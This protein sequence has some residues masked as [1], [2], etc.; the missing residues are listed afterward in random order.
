MNPARRIRAL[1]LLAGVMLIDGYDLNAM[2]LAIAWLAPEMGL[3]PTSFALV[4]SADLL[5]LGL[6]ALLFAPLGDR[7]GRKPLIVGGCLVIA[8]ATLSTGLSGTVPAF[9]FWRLVTGIGLGTCLANV[10]A[11]SAEVA[12]Q[13]RRST[14]MA[15]VS[16][17]I[18]IGAMLAGF[19]APEVVA[20]GG[21]KMLF[22]IP[23]GIAL[24]LAILLAAVLE[25]GKPAHADKADAAKVPLVELLRPPLLLPM[26]VFTITY[27]IN[28]VALYMLVR[29]TPVLLPKAGFTIE[30]AARIQGLLQGG[31]LAVGIGLA[32]LLDRWK[33]GTTFVLGYAVVALSF[34]A[35]WA[36]PASATDLGRVAAHRGRRHNWHP[37]RADGAQPQALSQPGAL[38]RHRQRGRI[39]ANW[40]DRRSDSGRGPDRRRYFAGRLLPRSGDPGGAVRISGAAGAPRDARGRPGLKPVLPAGFNRRLQSESVRG[41][42]TVPVRRAS[43]AFRSIARGSGP[44]QQDR[45]PTIR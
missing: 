24:A 13:G 39:L 30:L 14:V 16:A 10:S 20:F 40:R 33:P 26:A 28:A 11:L 31:G 15:T 27:M 32:F 21:W 41:N 29:W 9:A 7:I 22:F 5:G 25:G 43:R 12:P 3:E 35:I 37:H 38:L 23:A 45:R 17:G 1:I 34:V 44:S 8:V 6:G 19:T 18:G 42:A 4:Q 2:S 36:T